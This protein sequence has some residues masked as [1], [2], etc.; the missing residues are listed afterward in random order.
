P[1]NKQSTF[2]TA[3]PIAKDQAD[4]FIFIFWIAAVVFVMVEAAIIYIAIRYRRR[5][6]SDKLPHQTH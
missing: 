3:G 6:D 1:D 4:L 2:G 5:S